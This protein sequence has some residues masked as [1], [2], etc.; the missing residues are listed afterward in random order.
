MAR[1][2]TYL[3]MKLKSLSR[4]SLRTSNFGRLDGWC[5]EW[6]GEVVGELTDCRQEDMFWDSYQIIPKDHLHQEIA[7]RQ[8]LWDGC[9]F[10][11]KNRA[12]LTYVDDAFSSVDPISDGRVMMRGLYITNRRNG[13][14]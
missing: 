6:D 1:F 14:S 8:D 4:P 5:I 10:R 11:F 3:L 12:N 9:K 2:V 13:R 7:F